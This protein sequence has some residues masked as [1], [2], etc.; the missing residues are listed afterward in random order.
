ML[1]GNLKRKREKKTGKKTPI[2]SKI[3]GGERGLR[4]KNRARTEGFLFYKNIKK[5]KWSR[6]PVRKDRQRWK[7]E[8][9]S[10]WKKKTPTL[11]PADQKKTKT[12][13]KRA[14]EKKK[15]KEKKRS[16]PTPPV[17]FSDRKWQFE[18]GGEIR[19]TNKR[20]GR[21]RGAGRRYGNYGRVR[22]VC[23]T[24][25]AY[26]VRHQSLLGVHSGF[27]LPAFRVN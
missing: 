13:L 5:K 20:R 27:V 12:E 2:D 15:K 25:V 4:I 22:E 18:G 17:F 16:G 21:G 26:P 3:E 6:Y 11:P 1:F 14:R 8:I 7:N 24:V 23:V 19:K 10:L 9:R